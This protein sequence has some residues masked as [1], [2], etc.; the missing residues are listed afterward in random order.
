MDEVGKD[1]YP[2]STFIK[3]PDI[4][5]V[6][7]SFKYENNVVIDLIYL[8]VCAKASIEPLYELSEIANYTLACQRYLGAPNYY[9]KGMLQ[10]VAKF[11]EINGEDL[12]TV[13]AA[14]DQPEMFE[15]LT[16]IDNANFDQVRHEFRR[17]I[18]KMDK[19]NNLSF[20]RT[21]KQFDYANDRY[22][23]IIDFLD[24]LDLKRRIEIK[25]RERLK[26]SIRQLIVF[27]FVNEDDGLSG[28]SI[29]VLN[30]AR[31][32]AYWH[33]SLY[34]DSYLHKLPIQ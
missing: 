8:Q 21:P 14:L 2:D 16:C 25:A 1:L 18:T 26:E 13:I 33:L 20:K 31:I 22:W 15:S 7:L 4:R 5:N 19:R 32:E 12:A 30:K 24:C 17:F 28:I 11:P 29:A 10:H 34:C 23:D 3:V 27:K 6:L 9:Y